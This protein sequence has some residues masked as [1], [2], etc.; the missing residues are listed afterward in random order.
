[1]NKILVLGS[2]AWGTAL[3]Q[4]LLD[5]KDNEVSIYGINEQQLDD[6]NHQRNEQ[7]FGEIKLSKYHAIY[8]SLQILKTKKFDYILIAIP[9]NCIESCLDEINEVSNYSF[10]LI[11]AS[12]GFII[13]S[14]ETVSDLVQRKKYEKVESLSAILGPGFAIDVI[15]KKFTVLN[16][17]CEDL[18]IAKKVCSLFNNDYFVTYISSDLKG[19]ELLANMKNPLA[20]IVGILKGL[21]VSINVISAF[22]AKGIQE[23]T[24]LLIKV[25]CDPLSIVQYCGIGDIFL[26]CTST[27]SRNYSYGLKIAQFNTNELANKNYDKTVEG[28][29]AIIV[30]YHLFEKYHIASILYKNLYLVINNKL[31]AKQFYEKTK[32]DLINNK[33]E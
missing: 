26:T 23:I 29:E 21:D 22:I 12:K 16:V 17:L 2:G 24:Q 5:N 1:M 33:D 3:S 20:I 7:F 19:A 30:I 4:V 18:L 31:T 8:N 32:S 9:S 27:K 28:K 25:N 10:N 11:N 14:N 15:Q 6:L 13:K